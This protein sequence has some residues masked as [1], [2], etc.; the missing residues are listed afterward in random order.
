MQITEK[1]R[2]LAAEMGALN[3]ELNFLAHLE[4]DI[5]E[6]RKRVKTKYRKLLKELSSGVD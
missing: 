1:E 5:K 3:S 2:R 6:E 4:K